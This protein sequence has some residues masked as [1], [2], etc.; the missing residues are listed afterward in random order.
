MITAFNPPTIAQF[1]A[2][3]PR[4]WPYGPGTDKVTPGDI[5]N[6]INQAYGL[7]NPSLWN[8]TIPSFSATIKGD[9]TINSPTIANLT[10]VS[11]L[12]PGQTVAGAG[13][14]VASTILLVGASSIVISANATA[15][16]AQVI[17]T[18][19]GTSGYTVSEA[20]IAYCLLSAHLLVLSLQNAGGL[21]A[22][23]S[24]QG[25]GSSGGGVVASKTV[26]S[27]SV[28]Y[29]LPD[30]VTKS[31]SLSQYMR[32]GYGQQYLQLLA[33][34]LPGRRVVVVGGEPTPFS[35]VPGNLGAP[36]P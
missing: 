18:V 1:Q 13:I 34:K 16:T 3:F 35:G 9:T 12:L 7:F 29:A 30:F 17:L 2:Q 26:G 4:D 33:P 32:T 14:P 24:F 31:P 20:I 8:S 36:I 28:T 11:G 15:T 27:V 5:Q 23:S 21:S 19:G 10:S 25:P 6:A 22:P